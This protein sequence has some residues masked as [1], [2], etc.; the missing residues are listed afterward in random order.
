MLRSGIVPIILQSG[1]SVHTNLC[2]QLMLVVVCRAE[3][4]VGEALNIIMATISGLGISIAVTVIQNL[5][6]RYVKTL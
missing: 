3:G 1:C 5:S 6:V 4:T 2:S